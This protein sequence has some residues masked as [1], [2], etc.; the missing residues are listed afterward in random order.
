M[1]ALMAGYIVILCTPPPHL[2]VRGARMGDLGGLAVIAGLLVTVHE[3]MGAH[4]L[5]GP[6]SPGAA[7]ESKHLLEEHHLADEDAVAELYAT[8]SRAE[9]GCDVPGSGQYK[10]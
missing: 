8:P 1:A 5:S 10:Q 9:R 2:G 4:R 7:D 6:P 3:D